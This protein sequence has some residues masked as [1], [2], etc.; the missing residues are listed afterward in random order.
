[1]YQNMLAKDPKE[2]S[3]I[4]GTERLRTLYFHRSNEL[5]YQI[6]S[7]QPF[8]TKI[9]VIK[10]FKIVKEINNLSNKINTWYKSWQMRL[11]KFVPFN[12]FE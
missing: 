7:K 8:N 1:M 12:K 4:I 11:C 6:D 3:F 10:Q 5:L 9:Q 2:T